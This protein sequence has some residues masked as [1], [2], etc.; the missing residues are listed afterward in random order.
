MFLAPK[1]GLERGPFCASLFLSTTPAINEGTLCRLHQVLQSTR[2][3]VLGRLPNLDESCV[4]Y[5]SY[6]WLLV[7][8]LCLLADAKTAA[9][10]VQATSRAA[11]IEAYLVDS[12]GLNTAALNQR[13]AAA[14]RN[15]QYHPI[16]KYVPV[17][18]VCK[19]LPTI[20]VGTSDLSLH[21]TGS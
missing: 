18:L 13:I 11:C 7:Q 9:A 19:W 16:S 1:K 20:E 12:G 5:H 10:A 3:Y 14:G 8:A 2:F 6:L 4:Q 15:Y 17:T 21:Q